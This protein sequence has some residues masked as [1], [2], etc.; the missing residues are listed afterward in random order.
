MSRAVMHHVSS[1]VVDFAPNT[2]V[3]G[4]ATNHPTKEDFENS[5]LEPNDAVNILNYTVEGD[6]ISFYIEF[7]KIASFKGD[8]SE[9]IEQNDLKH[10]IHIGDNVA[11]RGNNCFSGHKSLKMFWVQ[12]GFAGTSSQHQFNRGVQTFKYRRLGENDIT[13]RR[14]GQGAAN[15]CRFYFPEINIGTIS[16]NNSTFGFASGGANSVLYTPIENAT[17]NGGQP[18]GDIQEYLNRNVGTVVYITNFTI[19]DAV[20]NL[21]VL[22]NNGIVTFNFTT[23]NSSNGIGFYE[24]YLDTGDGFTKYYPVGEINTSGDT[25]DLSD[26]GDLS[27]LKIRLATCDIYWNGSGLETDE[28]RR[29]FSNE[30]II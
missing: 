29:V 23:P 13:P 4:I 30:V 22:Q 7:L 20:N 15:N 27:G 3:G 21:T 25:L 17:N 24:V 6:N 8:V 16:G 19:P 10:F 26:Y 1:L 12:K 5:F 18:D 11:Q 14:Y 28:N 2:F 9:N